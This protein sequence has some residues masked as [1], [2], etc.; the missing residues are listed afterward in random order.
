MADT[1]EAS[2]EDLR[3][4][5]RLRRE[6]IANVSHDLRSP[7]AAMQG[8]LETIMMKHD[9]LAPDERERYLEIVLRNAR[10]LSTLV[11]ELFELS[12]LD[13]H[14]IEPQREAFSMAELVQD[15]VM[16]FT[17]MAEELNVTLDAEL[18]DHLA[19]VYADIALVERAI[20]N[21]IDN[22]LRYTPPG[23]TVRIVPSNEGDAVSVSVIDTGYGIPPEDLPHIFERFY[24]VEKSRAPDKGG[25]GL[26]LAI[27]K[28]ILEL[29]G[30]TLNVQ[31]IVDRGTTFSFNLPAW[32][33]ALSSG[34]SLQMA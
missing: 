22:A 32:Q 8:Y 11:G 17:P 24:R 2:V 31:S 27:T 20:S 25:T 7:L 28:K 29:H 19:R 30:S 21:L 34:Q 4:T 16:Q 15:L 10:S 23:G 12:M 13:A 3:R 6:L 5:D 26:G 18:P 33:K 9:D 14:Q 1:I